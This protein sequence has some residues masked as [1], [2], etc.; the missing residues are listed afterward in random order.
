MT[1]A[2]PEEEVILDESTSDD[3]RRIRVY[4]PKGDFIIT[5]PA[6]ARITFGYFNP[7]TPSMGAAERGY[8]SVDN[9][10]RQTA[11][12]IYRTKD[13]QLAC[14]IGVRGFR[15]LSISLT[16]YSQKVTVE[17]KVQEDDE[18]RE[19]WGTEQRQLVAKTEDEYM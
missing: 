10:A 18:Y 13:D 3:E 8:G 6:K 19:W 17:R 9:V 7:A 4:D 12:R 1:N 11:L 2:Q 15:D 16:R 14:F 5:V